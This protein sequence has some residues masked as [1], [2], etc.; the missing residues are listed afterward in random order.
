M[1]LQ[2]IKANSDNKVVKK[3]SYKKAVATLFYPLAPAQ[4]RIT[5][6]KEQGHNS[7]TK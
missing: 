7:K 1:I 3:K 4:N 6:L 2:K 5:F